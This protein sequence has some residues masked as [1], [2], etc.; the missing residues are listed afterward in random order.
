MCSRNIVRE[1]SHICFFWR[2]P[3]LWSSTTDGEH[4]WGAD[5]SSWVTSETLHSLERPA[6]FSPSLERPADLCLQSK[7]TDLILSFQVPCGTMNILFASRIFCLWLV[8]GTSYF[9]FFPVICWSYLRTEISVILS[10]GNK[11]HFSLSCETTLLMLSCD[12]IESAK[13]I[14]A[15]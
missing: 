6:E 8:I 2:G 15:S 14:V 13:F 1:T 3:F 11:L 5:R 10:T 4:T 12:R 7:I 9:R